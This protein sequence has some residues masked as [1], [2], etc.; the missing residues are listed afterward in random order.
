MRS[1]REH[2]R[3]GP[4][5]VDG[6]EVDVRVVG[7]RRAE[8]L[9][10]LGLVDVVALLADRARELVDQADEVVPAPEVGAALHAAGLR[11]QDVEVGLD[12][13]VD[14]GALDLHRDG[15]AVEQH[16]H[17]HLADARGCGRHLVELGEQLLERLPEG[18]LDLVPHLLERERLHG[19][20][21]LRELRGEG[22]GDEVGPHRE[23]LADLR[24]RGAEALHRAAEPLLG[25]EVRIVA[26]GPVAAQR[27]DPGR[28]HAELV[29]ERAEPL[30]EHHG[31]DAA[32]AFTAADG[33]HARSPR[34]AGCGSQAPTQLLSTQGVYPRRA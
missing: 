19:V 24:E 16:G 12:D 27:R 14:V 1:S 29:D 2:R 9:A 21:K 10:V 5:P 34:R 8:A 30:V 6:G 22:C 15:R 32:V 28:A 17:V 25:R 31:H 3:G 4:V 20:L 13:L 33:G 23:H 7:E 26:L 18:A 11:A